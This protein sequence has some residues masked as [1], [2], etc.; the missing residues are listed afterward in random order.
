MKKLYMIV[1]AIAFSMGM[2]GAQNLTDTAGF[3]NLALEPDSFWDGSDLSGGFSS[4]GFNFPNSYNPDWQTWV[5]WVYTNMAD[6][7]TN[8]YTNIYSAITA[9]GYDTATSGKNYAVCSVPLD[10]M[11]TDPIPAPLYFEDGNPHAVEG[12]YVTNNSWAA[13]SMENGD[14]FAK[15]FGGDSGDDPDWFRLSIFGYA[16]GEATDTVAFYLADYRFEDN[17]ED[18]I[19]KEWEWVDLNS[20]GMVDSLM[21]TLHSSDVGQYGMN[22][23]A[24]FCADDL[25]VVKSG[26]G[27]GNVK[28]DISGLNIYPNPSNGIYH[29]ELSGYTQA[30]LS[31]FNSKGRAVYRNEDYRGEKID[32]RPEAKGVYYLRLLKDGRIATGKIIKH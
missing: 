10:M 22:T 8:S 19:V 30:Q 17:S 31:I 18:Y 24:Y 27:T 25:V 6:D 1:A 9:S 11:T 5:Q 32:I 15:K 21:F 20:L 16:E 23:P 13:L 28:G 12:F 14:A 3:E 4:G 2:A 7:T 26:A 29:V